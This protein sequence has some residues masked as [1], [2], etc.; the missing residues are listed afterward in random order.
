MLLRRIAQKWP[1]YITAYLKGKIAVQPSGADTDL[2]RPAETSAEMEQR[3]AQR[4]AMG[5]TDED[6]VCIYT[7]RFTKD[8]NPLLLAKAVDILAGSGLRFLL[9]VHWRRRS[10]MK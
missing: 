1:M 9:I 6:I 10:R 3:S 7:G 4:K 2:F 5:Y 8:K